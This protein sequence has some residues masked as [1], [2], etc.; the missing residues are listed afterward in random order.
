MKIGPSCYLYIV[1]YSFNMQHSD[2]IHRRV[3]ADVMTGL[4]DFPAVAILGPRQCG[5]STLAKRLIAPN[6]DAVY[7]DLE[8]PADLAKLSDPLLF[9]G[10]NSGRLV[11]LDEIQRAPEIFR[12]LRSVIDGREQNGQF[13]LLG[14]ASPNL[15]RQSSESLAGRLVYV[16]LTPFLAP[17]VA[18]EA[19]DVGLRRLWLRGGF[20][21]SF[22]ARSDTTSARWLR[23]FVA[24]FLERDLPQLGVRTPASTLRRLWTMCAH[25]H[26]Q[27]LNTSRVGASM[28]VSHTSIR[29]YVDLLADALVL[30][31]LPPCLPNLGKRLTKSPKVYVRDTGI[32]HSLLGIASTNELLGHPVVGPSWEGLVIETVVQSRPTW[33]ASFYR[34]SDGTE[35]DLVLER[36]NRRLAVECKASS[37]PAAGRGLRNAITDLGIEHAWVVAPVETTYPLAPNITAAPLCACLDELGGP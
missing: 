6:A 20:P 30:R 3:E 37:A 9:F 17:E 33:D 27:M 22:L 24:T 29:K 18:G 1:F 26:G 5:K 15:I 4:L 12:V 13:L 23:S 28:G 10:A 36:G 11:C 16:E 21:R 19:D 8:N 14:S 25:L 32:L 34:T 31:I 7:L 35:I 2:Y